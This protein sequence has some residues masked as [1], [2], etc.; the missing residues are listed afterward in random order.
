M[1]YDAFLSHSHVDRDWT[2]RLHDWI[3]DCDY[4]GRPLRIWLDVRVLDPGQLSSAREL[5]S[6]LDRSHRV[7]LVLSEASL[8]STWVR[9]EIDYFLQQHSTTDL[10]L[11]R[12]QPCDVPDRL[13]G[14]ELINWPP[15]GEDKALRETLLH[16]LTPKAD[17]MEEYSCGHAVRRTFGNARY[18]LP[19]DY[20]PRPTPAAKQML[21]AL[22]ANDIGDLDQEGLAMI[23]FDAAGQFVAELDADESYATRMVLGEV[24]AICLLRNPAWAVIGRE[25]I[26][27]DYVDDSQSSFLTKRNRA[28]RGKTSKPSTTNLLF[29][30]VEAASKLA[31]IDTSRVDLSTLAA[32]LVN[33]DRHDSLDTQQEILARI[34]ARTL[35]KLRGIPE[36]RV[37]IHA[38]VNWGGYASQLAAAGAI[39]IGFKGL[40]DSE[41]FYTEELAHQAGKKKG[42]DLATEAPPPDIA[43][44]LF[45]PH[46]GLGTNID[47]MREVQERQREFEQN[48]G[49]A[50]EGPWPVP[51]YAPAIAELINGPIVGRVRKVT[52]ANMED[53]A[54]RL[55]PRDVACLTEARIVDALFED[56][57]AFL[58]NEI[59]IG[60]PLDERLRRRGI[61]FACMTK[62]S[63]NR[64]HDGQSLV[65]WPASK[66]RPA[67]GF[68]T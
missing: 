30:V 11:I 51:C 66:S 3:A 48:F 46:S 10:I 56:A 14:C 40:L 7:I 34:T 29:A 22:T 15:T 2:R 8:K 31:A 16:S 41:D 1:S 49:K 54:D 36:V 53:L 64:L 39:S 67:T 42:V 62:D 68:L 13:A 35:G 5:E 12:Q 65:V 60:S 44:L 63:I 4:F 43:R 57:G 61:R 25:Y 37:L 52:L 6:A 59:E 47:L 24:M 55:G 32:L 50:V 58:L 45:D 33:L 38:L 17:N 28:L 20:D 9:H 23:G 27:K 21:S 18:G 26:R 19:T